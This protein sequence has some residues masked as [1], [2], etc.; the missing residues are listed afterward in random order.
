MICPGVIVNADG[1]AY[2]TNRALLDT[3]AESLY[4]SFILTH[5]LKKF[6]M[7]KGLKHIETL[8]QTTNKMIDAFDVEYK[9]T[10]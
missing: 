9:H 5:E 4:I 2:I 1:I 3:D 6:P 8:L 10:G 7:R